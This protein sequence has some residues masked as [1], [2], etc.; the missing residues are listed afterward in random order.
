MGT[1]E[2]RG[3]VCKRLCSYQLSEGRERTKTGSGWAEEGALNEQDA[4]LSG[5]A[6]SLAA[7]RPASTQHAG[8]SEPPVPGTSFLAGKGHEPPGSPAGRSAPAILLG[9]HRKAHSK[10]TPKIELA[11]TLSSAGGCTLSEGPLS[12]PAARARQPGIPSGW[13]QLL[14][15]S[16]I[17]LRK[18]KSRLQETICKPAG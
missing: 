2:Q 4:A 5:Y 14:Q 18:G 9:F 7:A 15:E 6:A 3:E 10:C 8:L 12:S 11:L 1:P 13:P 16:H 17:F